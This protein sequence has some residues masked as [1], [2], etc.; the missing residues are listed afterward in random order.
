MMK[1]RHPAADAQAVPRHL[2]DDIQIACIRVE[3]QAVVIDRAAEQPGTADQ[4]LIGDG[5]AP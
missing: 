4:A 3:T 2:D 5:L 1:R